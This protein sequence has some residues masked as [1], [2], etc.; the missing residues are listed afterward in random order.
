MKK[1][2]FL[3]KIK[4]DR[5][6]QD[7]PDAVFVTDEYRRIIVFN[8]MAEQI[9]GFRA[10]E[11]VGMYC[12]DVFK[13]DVFK[14][15]SDLKKAIESNKDLDNIEYEITDIRNKKIPIIA[16][17]RII[18][19][20]KGEFIGVLESFKEISGLKELEKALIKEKESL[21]TKVKNRTKE[22]EREREGLDRRVRE[23]TKELE[24]SQ[25]ALMNILE[26]VE[27]ERIRA[28]EEKNKTL[29]VLTNFTDGLIVFDGEEKVSFANPVIEKIFEIKAEEILGKKFSALSQSSFLFSLAS[30]FRGELKEIFR[31]EL[32]L[33]ENLILEVSGSPVMN[34][35]Q[36][37]GFLIITHDVTREK[38]VERM[39]S[40]FVS[41]AAH[42]LRT[43][44]A[45]IKWTL[46]MI[47]DGDA[48]DV[49]MEQKNLLEK[50]YVSNER[51]IG[52]INDLL[53]VTR[54]EEGRHVY[55]FAL[56]D[57][58]PI[59]RFL[60]DSYKGEAARRKIH[61][62]FRKPL[63]KMPKLLL[64]AE[65]IKLVIQNLLENAIR[66]TLP[67]GRVTVSLKYDK[68]EIEVEISDTG[69]GIP[70]DQQQRIFAKF[71]RSE[72]ALRMETEGSG[73]GLFISKNI[74]ESHKGR[75]WFE[76]E[77]NKG[78]KFH[79]AI[80]IQK[81]FEEFLKEF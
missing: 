71:F 57:I 51:M 59:V 3:E 34:R 14:T 36:K 31:K 74:V 8:R 72:N 39:K 23:R 6:L 48:G 29:T 30:L 50:T 20:E 61:F 40:E 67:N 11:A 75:I 17:V 62:E 58:E 4:I 26:D 15:E 70:K 63:S 47:L 1:Q 73:L 64:D 21:K 18:R 53:D 19:D 65:K 44:L 32:F 10:K 60:F 9:T 38:A 46:K 37:V 69:I 68:K 80:P 27:G 56:S 7:L 24:D 5:L 52:L 2:S 28:E 49:S 79:I 81:E 33:K 76:S 54:I 16:N 66:Y 25:K 45:A 55:K 77:E 35:G 78:S 22:L 41:I 43:P 13:D 42:Q 12:R